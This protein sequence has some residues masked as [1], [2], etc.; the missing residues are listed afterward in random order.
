VNAKTKSLLFGWTVVLCMLGITLIPLFIGGCLAESEIKHYYKIQ[1]LDAYGQ[2]QQ[3]Y[4]SYDYPWGTDGYVSFKQYPTGA[5][6]KMHCAYVA[7]DIGTN[8]PSI[9]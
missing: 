2:V 3:I 9:K 7:E 4:Y 5:S 8:K 1:R 6:I